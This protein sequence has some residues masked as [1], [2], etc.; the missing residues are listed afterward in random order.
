MGRRPIVRRRG[1]SPIFMAPTHRRVAPAKY[2]ELHDGGLLSGTVAQLHHDPGRGTPLAEVRLDDGATYYTV[3]GEGLY[4][5]Q[6]IEVGSGAA[7]QL[8]ST[9]PLGRIP[10]GVMV[11][12]AER[13]PGDGGGLFRASGAYAVVVGKVGDGV[14]LKDRKGRS[15]VLD[16]GCRATLGLAAGG[17]RTEKPFLKAGPKLAL[18]QSRG[19]LY[20]RVRGVAMISAYHPFGGGRHQHEGKASSIGRGAPPGRKV[21]L[22]AP[23]RTGR[24]RKRKGEER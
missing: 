16:P 14:L 21:G 6:R 22:I 8:G 12:N 11:F 5:G 17:G 3:A 4:V 19:R 10:E 15:I 9:L 7:V 2:P 23:R 18:M 24:G 13:R 1:S 20:P